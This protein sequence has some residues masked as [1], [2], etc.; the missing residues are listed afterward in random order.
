MKHYISLESARIIVQLYF[1]APIRAK[2]STSAHMSY[3]TLGDSDHAIIDNIPSA[4][5]TDI[6]ISDCDE[7][8]SIMPGVGVRVSKLALLKAIQEVDLA[9]LELE[10]IV[11]HTG[12]DNQ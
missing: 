3:Y 1:D 7:L 8:C 10:M 6:V 2:Y 11:L 5:T 12:L 9:E 4:T